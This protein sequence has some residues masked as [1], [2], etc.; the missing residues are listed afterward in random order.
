MPGLR[1]S[2]YET[3][4]RNSGKNDES[5]EPMMTRCGEVRW[6]TAAAFIIVGGF[7]VAAALAMAVKNATPARGPPS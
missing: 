4:L 6:G 1:G 7:M 5:S 2:R 3:A